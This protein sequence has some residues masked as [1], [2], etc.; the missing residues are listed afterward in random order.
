M[1]ELTPAESGLFD[2]ITGHGSSRYRWID[3]RSVIEVGARPF[4]PTDFALPLPVLLDGAPI[5]FETEVPLAIFGAGASDTVAAVE[6]IRQRGYCKVLEITGGI[7][8][9]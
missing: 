4:E 7:E 6:A 9:L 5:P 2:V 3:V 8:W 1:A